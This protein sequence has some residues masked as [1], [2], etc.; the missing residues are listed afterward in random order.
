MHRCAWLVVLPIACSSPPRPCPC[1]APAPAKTV[2]APC[3][4]TSPVVASSTPLTCGQLTL[5]EAR[6]VAGGKGDK[7][8]DLMDV[9]ARLAACTETRPSEAE[10]LEV[11]RQGL[12]LDKV[13]GPKHPERVM[14]AAEQAVCD[15]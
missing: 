1:T 15:R 13:Y 11:R 8:P 5:R 3:P 4:Q 12:E 7:H 9:R 6:L 14:N 10:C 2:T